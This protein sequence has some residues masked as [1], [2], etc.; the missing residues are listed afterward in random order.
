MKEKKS[1]APRRGNEE[2]FKWDGNPTFGQILPLA[3]QHVLAAV[4]GVLHR[5]F[6]LQMQRIMQAEM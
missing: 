4:V 5:Q 3:A 1:E 6:W 2:L